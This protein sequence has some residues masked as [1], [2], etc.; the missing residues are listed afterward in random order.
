MEQRLIQQTIEKNW[1]PKYN[2]KTAHKELHRE[3]CR[4]WSMRRISSFQEEQNMSMLTYVFVVITK[5]YDAMFINSN[6]FSHNIS[7]I[8]I[9][10]DIYCTMTLPEHILFI[11]ESFTFAASSNLERALLMHR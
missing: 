11:N 9:A 5:N 10:K 7:Q 6:S 1:H 4:P 3:S 8:K 2:V